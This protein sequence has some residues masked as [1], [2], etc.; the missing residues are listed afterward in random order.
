[1]VPLASTMNTLAVV[2]AGNGIR[3]NMRYG[4]AGSGGPPMTGKL[5]R[6]PCNGG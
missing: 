1:M 6:K 3:S 2:N 4:T 5:G